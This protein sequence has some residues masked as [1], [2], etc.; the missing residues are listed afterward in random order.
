MSV[1]RIVVDIVVVVIVVI[2][3]RFGCEGTSD[4]L[5]SKDEYE[6]VR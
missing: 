3:W 6:R 5:G 4:A 2:V 1:A